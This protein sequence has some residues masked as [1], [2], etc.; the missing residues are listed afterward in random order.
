MFPLFCGL[1]LSQLVPAPVAAPTRTKML[2]GDVDSFALLLVVS[3]SSVLTTHL[4]PNSVVSRP[5]PSGELI[6]D[7]V[8]HEDGVHTLS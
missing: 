8:L 2:L 5:G 3:R 6:M 4:T 7:V 1:H